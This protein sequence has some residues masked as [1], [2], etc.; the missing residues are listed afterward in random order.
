M[1]RWKA[2][3]LS[4]A[5][6]LL[7]TPIAHKSAVHAQAGVKLDASSLTLQEGDYRE[8]RAEFDGTVSD[9]ELLQNGLLRCEK[10][11]QDGNTAKIR[12]TALAPGNTSVGVK[13]EKG[14]VNIPVTVEESSLKLDT[15]SQINLKTGESY[16]FLVMTG[17]G[18][19]FTVEA[20]GLLLKQMG[21]SDASKSARYCEITAVK[22]GNW[23]VSVTSGSDTAA[24]PVHVESSELEKKAQSYTSATNYLILTDLEAQRVAVF[25]KDGNAWSMVRA[26]PCSSGAPGME[27]PKGEYRVQGRG[28]WFYNRRLQS[29]GEWYVGFYGNYLFHSLPMDSSHKVQDYRLGVP[30]S[31]GCVRLRIEDAKWLYDNLPG[32][33]KVVIY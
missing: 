18:A 15:N 17:A 3:L 16:G 30:L 23:R 4:A 10:L 20:D 24:F 1:L 25:Q 28:K 7:I 6:V 11:E 12:V 8:L 26:F 27:T 14:S 31:H 32:N 9:W 13:T 5:A 21:W 22:A 2:V 29:G 33:S 19:D